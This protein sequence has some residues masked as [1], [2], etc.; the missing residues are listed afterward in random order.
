M[1]Y[2]AMTRGRDANTAYLHHRATEH[3]YQYEPP[4]IG[5]VT[6]TAPEDITQL[7][8]CVRSSPTANTS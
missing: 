2:V 3:E 4:D 8:S 5:R 6:R 1:P 7:E